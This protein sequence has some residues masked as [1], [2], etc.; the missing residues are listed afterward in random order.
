MNLLV[1]DMPSLLSGHTLPGAYSGASYKTLA[2]SKNASN[3]QLSVVCSGCSQW[4][5]GSLKADGSSLLAWAMG[6]VSFSQ[7]SINACAFIYHNVIVRFSVDF[8]AS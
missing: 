4:S 5:G 7:P 2:S 3:W 1:T 6:T 8:G